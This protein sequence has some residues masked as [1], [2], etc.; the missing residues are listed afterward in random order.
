MLA[1]AFRKI[2]ITALLL[3]PV[4]APVVALAATPPAL[5]AEQSPTMPGPAGLHGQRQGHGKLAGLLSPE[6]RAMLQLEMRD[7]I[8]SM[9]PADRLAFRKTQMQKLVAM[10]PADRQKFAGNL[11]SKWDALP[12][13]QKDRLRQ[14]LARQATPTPQA[15]N[16]Q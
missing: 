5:Q 8:K 2:A 6:Q 15:P 11:Q 7:Q 4:A 10:S 16:P 3:I 13:R 1:N 14:R 9:S 12:Q